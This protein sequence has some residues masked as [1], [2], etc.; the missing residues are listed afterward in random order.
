MQVSE[1][2]A[3]SSSEMSW[4]VIHT[5]SG[6]ENKA[7][8][9]LEIE[10]QVIEFSEKIKDMPLCFFLGRGAD[11]YVALEG[12]LKLKEVAYVPTQESPAGEMKHGP[13]ALVQ[14]GV[15]SIFGATDPST[16]DKIVSNIKEVQARGGTVI[17]VTTDD[18]HT[19]ERAADLTLKVPGTPFEYLN[20]VLSMI[21]L[22]LL[23][24]HI[25]RLKG[26]EI[27]QPRNL[28]KSVTVE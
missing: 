1:L 14:P 2:Q 9:A 23:A 28:A 6:Y 24:Y 12:A 10:P 4:Y 22:Q 8:L 7:K 16:L 15:V 5:Y 26:C 11:A 21:P 25:A 17:G 19:I 3:Q 18:D 13:L 27:D 20:A